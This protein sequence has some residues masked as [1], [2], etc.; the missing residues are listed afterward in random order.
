MAVL[1]GQNRGLI[2]QI[3][4]KYQG[5][6]EFDD[7]MQESYLGLCAAVDRWNRDGGA[8]FST[9]AVYWIRQQLKRYVYNSGTVKLPPSSRELIG[10]YEKLRS[11]CLK[12]W[13]REPSESEVRHY[14]DLDER[15]YTAL[16]D[17]LSMAKIGSLDSP[18]A[19]DDDIS[20]GDLLA[21][22]TDIEADYMVLAMQ[23]AVRAAV[24]SL[25]AQQAFVIRSHWLEDGKVADIGKEMGLPPESV[26]RLESK[27]MM[28]LRKPR[29]ARRLRPFL[30]DELETIAYHHIG[31]E[32]FQRTHTSSVEAAV[33][34]LESF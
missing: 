28:E 7:L 12:E 8:A 10:K 18:T 9:Y 3:A 29:N 19:A 15:E 17:G 21:D 32:K 30:V 5:Y 2:I 33:L 26:R 24:D 20:V 34:K 16:M 13:N 4:K 27:G 14:L 23:E 22:D 31:S 1:Y 11:S 25:E 6:A